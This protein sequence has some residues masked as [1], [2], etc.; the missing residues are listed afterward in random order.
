MPKNTN[1][2]IQEQL[3]AARRNQI[4]DAATTVFADKG[5]E[6][7]TIKDIARSAGIADGTIYL[8]F[9]NKTALLLGVLGRLNESDQP[10]EPFVSTAD[11]DIDTFFRSALR[12]RLQFFSP[13]G[14][15][16]AKIVL[17]EILVNTELRTLYYEKVIAP[18]FE[19]ADQ[20]LQQLIDEGRIRPFDVQLLMRS[21]IGTVLG[22][23]MLRLIGD[24]T[25][26]S[27]W[28]QLPDLIADMVLKGIQLT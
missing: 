20:F 2:T 28:D 13:Q 6:R 23:L 3:I 5:F 26:V 9:E 17:S 1:D 18:T 21:L 22:L 16:I 8:Y 27:Q 15:Q 7:S 24:S 4:L 10:L 14:L 12:Q 19:F 11:L 25:V